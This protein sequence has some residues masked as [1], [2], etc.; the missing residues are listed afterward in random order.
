MPAKCLTFLFIRLTDSER[1]I[2]TV[3][4]EM[5][6]MRERERERETGCGRETDNDGSR[7]K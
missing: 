6:S 3:S 1:E 4:G 7:V 2:K 5:K